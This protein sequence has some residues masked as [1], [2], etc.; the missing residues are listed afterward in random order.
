MPNF[1]SLLAEA[2]QLPVAERIHLI[3]A[4]WDTVPEESLPP[5]S[6]EWLAE[7]EKRSAEYD[8]GSVVTVPWEEIRADALRRLARNR[9]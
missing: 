1:A 2:A 3:E 4:L 8:S 9:D 7:I 6:D 5:L